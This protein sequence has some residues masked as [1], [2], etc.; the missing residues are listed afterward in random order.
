MYYLVQWL[1]RPLVD[2]FVTEKHFQK[3]DFLMEGKRL[4]AL[5]FLVFFLPGLPKDALTYLV[6]FNS[7]IKPMRLFILTTLGRTPA[8]ILTVYVG[9]NI[10]DGNFKAASILI[11]VMVALAILGLWIKRYIDRRAEIHDAKKKKE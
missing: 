7:K 4:E 11:L 10:W 9:G 6:S 1:G 5:V 8:T 2:R 3:F